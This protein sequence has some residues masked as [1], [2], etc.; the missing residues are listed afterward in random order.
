MHEDDRAIFTQ[1][2]IRLA[3][4]IRLVHAKTE[5][6]PVKQ[7]PYNE[8]RLRPLAPYLGHA[9][10]PLLR[11]KYIAHRKVAEACLLPH[12]AGRSLL[13]CSEASVQMLSH[14]IN[15]L[16]SVVPVTRR[17]LLIDGF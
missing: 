16:V 1:H 5:S 15:A 14:L 10:F 6:P 2:Y 9:V 7:R 12:I 13:S 3:W 11:S 17:R 8:F 4:H